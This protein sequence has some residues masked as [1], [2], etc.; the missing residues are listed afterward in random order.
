[1]LVC[2]DERNYEFRRYL[3][4]VGIYNELLT[5]MLFYCYKIEGFCFLLVCFTFV[6]C[7]VF[8][9]VRY[10]GV[11]YTFGLLDCIRFTRISL[12]RGSFLYILP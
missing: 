4:A 8:K 5:V 11:Y 1:M 12:Y 10:I 7:H 2:I 3:N 6:F 9:F